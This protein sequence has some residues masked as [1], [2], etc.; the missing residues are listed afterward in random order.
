MDSP[1]FDFVAAT[2]ALEQQPTAEEA[3]GMLSH[4]VREVLRII[5][6][7]AEKALDVL[8]KV[9]LEDHL[10][11]LGIIT[12]SPSSDVVIEAFEAGEWVEQGDR[13]L[14]SQEHGDEH[15]GEVAIS[16]WTPL[17]AKVLGLCTDTVPAMQTD[18]DWY[19]Q[20]IG[21]VSVMK[22]YVDKHHDIQ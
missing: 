4:E 14:T 20:R 12:V 7:D 13:T 2:K 18:S 10:V 11:E 8:R 16:E 21:Y 5:G 1:E 3:F 15:L 9:K 17:G 19:T 22:R 6:D